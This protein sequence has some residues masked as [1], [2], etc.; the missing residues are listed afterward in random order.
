VVVV[1]RLCKKLIAGGKFNSMKLWL[2]RR[3]ATTS[4]AVS[5]LRPAYLRVAREELNPQILFYAAAAHRADKHFRNSSGAR[6]SE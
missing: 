2:A 5:K 1:A 6:G 3:R 4:A